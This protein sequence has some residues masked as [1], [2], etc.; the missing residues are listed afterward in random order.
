MRL[1]VENVIVAEVGTA[2]DFDPLLRIDHR[3]AQSGERLPFAW[4]GRQLGEDT[5]DTVDFDGFETVRESDD[6][7]HFPITSLRT[8]SV[9]A[10]NFI[11]LITSPLSPSRI[12]AGS[13]P[14]WPAAAS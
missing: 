2:V 7:V 13:P 3:H 10:G 14:A 1:L 11:D 4:V 5:V 9:D 12:I 8:S 6:G